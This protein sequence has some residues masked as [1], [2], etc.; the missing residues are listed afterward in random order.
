[1]EGESP[2]LKTSSSFSYLYKSTLLLLLLVLKKKDNEAY[3]Y[4]KKFFFFC[5]VFKWTLLSYHK[6]KI[7]AAWLYQNSRP[8]SSW[9]TFPFLHRINSSG[10]KNRLSLKRIE[11]EK[12]ILRNHYNLQKQPQLLLVF[13]KRSI[14]DVWQGS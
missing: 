14:K 13:V 3:S 7:T 4:K 6:K 8:P 5:I 1:M 11:R 2:T 10:V 9:A 12:L